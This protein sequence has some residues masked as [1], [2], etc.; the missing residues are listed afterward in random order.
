MKKLNEMR[1]E[2]EAMAEKEAYKW[3]RIARRAEAHGCSTQ[4]V[5]EIREDADYAWY[6]LKTYPDRVLSWKLPFE[7]KYIFS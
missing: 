6:T 2:L 5:N 7:H 4:L 3:W 1:Y